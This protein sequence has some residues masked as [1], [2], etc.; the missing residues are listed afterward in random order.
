MSSK[1]YEEKHRVSGLKFSDLFYI[2]E[3]YEHDFGSLCILVW[4]RC[5][6]T[7]HTFYNK[8]NEYYNVEMRLSDN[9]FLNNDI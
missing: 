6:I 4:M 9:C 7:I 2:R 8:I 3:V 1:W 5:N